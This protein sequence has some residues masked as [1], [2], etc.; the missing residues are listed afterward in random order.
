MLEFNIN[1]S[2]NKIDITDSV[3]NLE[4]ELDIDF[5]FRKYINEKI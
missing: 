1:I 2:G 4:L 3:R 5:K